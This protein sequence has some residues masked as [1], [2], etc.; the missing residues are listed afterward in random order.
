[1]SNKKK[2]DVSTGIRYYACII[3]SVICILGIVMGGI[4][5]LN[6][7]A[8]KSGNHLSLA[9]TV[10]ASDIIK[11]I[12][13]I[14]ISGIGLGVL[15]PI[16]QRLRDEY[17]YDENGISKK[18]GNFS[19]LSKK[20]RDII[21]QQ[22]MIDM[23]RLLSSSSLKKITHNGSENPDRDM[24]ELIGLMNVKREMHE[25][26]SRI[27]YEMQK[28]KEEQEKAGKRKI[29]YDMSKISSSHM[30][31]Y[32]NPGTG[33]TTVARI[34]TGFLYQTGYIKKNQIIEID[35]NFL[36]GLTPGESTKKTRA[37][38]LKSL[39][40]V[41]F[42][43]EAYAILNDSCSQEII[44]TLVKEME[45]RRGEFVLIMA[46]YDQEMRKLIN[47]NPGFESR[48]KRYLYFENYTIDELQ[49]I[50]ISLAGKEG[51]NVSAEMMNLFVDRI[52]YETKQPGFGNARTVRNIMDKIVDRHATNLMDDVDKPEEKY[53]LTKYDMPEIDSHKHI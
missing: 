14:V 39:G 11:G 10:G 49:Q 47:S 13:I 3:A 48:I 42:I 20:E 40:G 32:G 6:G 26:F 7:I 34:I 51:F 4:L 23:E 35:G 22:K 36:T 5:I 21:E 43:D 44:A 30:V 28:Q 1:M 15:T 41:L 50:F 31:F 38:I 33:K 8:L 18:K 27:I 9:N 25:M 53:I 52:I 12:I 37:L 17:E 46:G 29:V 2:K 19:S 24:K 45:D 16:R